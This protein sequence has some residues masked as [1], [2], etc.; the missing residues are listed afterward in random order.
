M[1]KIIDILYNNSIVV[2][3]IGFIV[4]VVSILVFMQTRFYGNAVPQIAVGSA[5]TGFVLYLIGRVLMATRKRYLQKKESR[6]P[7]AK[8]NP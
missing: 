3:I 7:L 8:D 4:S 1:N 6:A 5:I 2:M